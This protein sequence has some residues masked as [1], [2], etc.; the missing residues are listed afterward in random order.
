[1]MPAVKSRAVWYGA[2]YGVLLTAMYYQA[3]AWLI[4]Y[5]WPREDY[6]YCYLVPLIVL[7]LIW[8][9]RRQWSAEASIRSWRGLI[10][11]LS[12]V[13]LYWFGELAGEFYSLY[14]SSWMVV[15]GLIWLHAGWKKIRVMA[16]PLF[17][18]LFLFPLP[19]ILNTKL[20]FNLK[21][22]SS[23]IG[24]KMI[25][26]L[27]MSAYREGNIIDL[28]FTQLQVVDACSG[29]R[30]L[31]PLLL[32]SVLMTYFYRTSRWKS[33]LLVGST[34][35]L[36]VMTNSLRITLTAVLYPFLGPAIVEG[37]THDISGFA[38]FAVSLLVLV[39]EVRILERI[40]PDAG[41]SEAGKGE[42]AAHR[43]G[44]MSEGPAN[45]DP[46]AAAGDETAPLR[47]P[48]Y[49]VAVAVLAATIA[50]HA[51]AD[52]REKTPA[53]KPVSQFP[54]VV[55]EWSG[56]RQFL[57]KQF[58]ETLQ[59]SDYVS[60]DYWKPDSPPVNIYVAYYESQRK[61]VSIHSPETCLPGSGWIFKQAGTIDVSLPG[62]GA[63]PMR[64][65]RAEMEKNGSR[66]LVYYWFNERGRILTNAYEMKVYNFWDA[67][68][69]RRT[70]GA[71]IRVISPVA[72]SEKIEDTEK[73]IQ[74]FIGNIIPVM[75]GF[76]P[77]PSGR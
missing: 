15:A 21:L 54:L 55:G 53:G 43:D 35:P 40:A 65:M 57:D 14:L 34:V 50:V 63:S 10:V 52:F 9:K 45:N 48:Q 23:E 76:I 38:I 28:G 22:I 42:T 11:V 36:S 3:Y 17:I 72:P 32:L 69:K 1:M 18:S 12:G 68:V 67:L 26:L 49:V 77:G 13:L 19:N 56:K 4:Q 70:D 59:F 58:I 24:V 62:G 33:L 7:Y 31:M 44:R 66:Q 20:T 73:R 30:Y 64:V 61:G 51:I 37:L 74:S 71:L 16:F 6:N 2:I 25:H 5:D 75:N 8:E 60:I 39:A 47:Q 29:L 41:G 46:V 27:G